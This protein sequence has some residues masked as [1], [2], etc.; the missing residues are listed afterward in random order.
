MASSKFLM[1]KPPIFLG[2]CTFS[3]YTFAFVACSMPPHNNFCNI[4]LHFLIAF[5][6]LPQTIVKKH[7]DDANIELTMRISH[8]KGRWTNDQYLNFSLIAQL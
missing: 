7:K 1:F 2:T 4:T 3:H 6:D 5:L 8:T